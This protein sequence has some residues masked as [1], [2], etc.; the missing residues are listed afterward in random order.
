MKDITKPFKIETKDKQV[1]N[2]TYV[3][4]F[5]KKVAEDLYEDVILPGRSKDN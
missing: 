5:R 4:S 2:N 3:P 1:I